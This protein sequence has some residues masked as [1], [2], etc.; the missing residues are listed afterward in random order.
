MAL[1]CLLFTGILTGQSTLTGILLDDISG[2]PFKNVIVTSDLPAQSVTGDDGSFSIDHKNGISLQLKFR[3]NDEVFQF[4]SDEIVNRNLDLGSIRFIHTTNDASAIPTIIIDENDDQE[5]ANISGLLQSGDDLFG[6]QTNY[7]FSPARFRRRGLENLYS[8][9]YL[10]NTPVNDLESGNIFFSSWSGLN[11]AMRNDEVIVGAE[12]ADWGFGSIAGTSNVDLRASSQW[13]RKQINYAVTNRNYRNRIMGTYSTGLQPSGWAWSFTGSRRWAQEGYIP[14]TFYDGWA[15]YGG[16]SKKLNEHHSLHLTALGTPYQRGGS[17]TSIAEMYELAGDHYYNS[18]WG[19]QQGEKR[20]ARIYSGFQPIFNLRHDWNTG[21]K[22][23]ITTTLGYQKGKS[24]IEAL[25]WL[26]GN[27]PRPDYYRRLP[28]YVSDP[29][30]AEQMRELLTSNKDLLQIQWDRLYEINLN[31]NFTVDHVDGIEGNTVSGRLSKYIMEKRIADMDKKSGNIVLNYQ[32]NDQSQLY[33]G[34]S[35]IIQNTRNYKEVSDLLGGEFY[36]D[37]DKFAETDFPGND[38]ALQNDLRRPNRVVREG[39]QFGWDYISNIRQQTGWASYA[40]NTR[41]LEIAVAGSVKNHVYWREGLTQNGKFPDNSYGDGAKHNFFLPSGKGL[42]RY[43]FDGR[44]YLTLSGMISEIAPTFRNA[45][46]SP[47]TRDNVVAGLETENLQLGEARYDY[48]SPYLKV[49]VSGFYIT[50]K[51][52]IESTN[53]YHDDERSFVNFSLTNIDKRFTGVEAAVQY[54]LIPGLMFNGAASVGQYIYTSRPTATITQDNDGAVLQQNITVYAKNFFVSQTPQRSYTIGGQYRS[55]H[56]WTVW[57]N[58]NRFEKN[59]VDF[60]PLR[61]TEQAVDL[62]EGNSD[63]WNNIIE[64]EELDPAWTLDV[65]F[66]K[67]W[68]AEWLTEDGRIV[69]N[70]SV[71][72]LLNNQDY[73]NTAYEQ[74]RFD[75]ETKDPNRF[76][77]R[78]GYMQGLTF[79][80]QV[81]LR[82]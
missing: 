34:G 42:L 47:R 36:L 30:V 75:F 59:Y 11:D 7:T 77:A 67:S 82:F 13:S 79:F 38:E 2:Q 63:Q 14:G 72:N 4:T 27:D 44:N 62:V 68:L 21:D 71:S 51:D 55:K 52:G 25:D 23:T 48:K 41:K 45:Y 10:N 17:S 26:Y 28:G 69:L 81:S 16:V 70:L 33:V 43:K 57:I 40:L 32:L 19:Y 73:I 65:S 9:A 24:A 56:F 58:L 5:S 1:V 29:A 60:N 46:V 66:N 35:I 3:F 15:F 64:Q 76:P 31:S 22:L 8:E 53:F 49:A 50:T 20:N 12:M 80:G 18:F 37:W 74:N 78:Y 6:F 39:D 61:R 54:T